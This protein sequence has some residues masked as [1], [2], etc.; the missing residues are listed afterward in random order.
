MLTGLVLENFKAI[1]ARQ[2]IPFASITLI[3]GPNSAGKSSILQSL[4]L[5]RAPFKTG[6]RRGRPGP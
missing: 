5:L 2:V 6:W 3:F 4:L 1:G